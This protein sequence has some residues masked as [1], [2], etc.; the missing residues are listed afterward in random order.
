MRCSCQKL[1]YVWGARCPE[2]HLAC[3]QSP[4]RQTATR[5]NGVSSRF[6][7]L[8]SAEGPNFL[9]ATTLAKVEPYIA[10]LTRTVQYLLRPQV[11]YPVHPHSSQYVLPLCRTHQPLPAEEVLRITQNSNAIR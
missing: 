7:Q 4:C 9:S 8:G 3:R 6:S 2:A 10:I 5:Q 11:V 1:L